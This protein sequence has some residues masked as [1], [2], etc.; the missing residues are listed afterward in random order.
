[1]DT[2]EGVKGEDESVL[3]TLLW[4]QANFMLAFK[5]DNKTSEN[6]SSLF[7]YLKELLGYEVFHTL[8]PV[9]ISLL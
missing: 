1:M 2:V 7:L 4:R 8:F 6:V 3:L 5:L 9:G